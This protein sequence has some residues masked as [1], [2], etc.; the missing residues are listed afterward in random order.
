M[1][2]SHAVKRGTTKDIRDLKKIP[3]P[4]NP[5]LD[6]LYPRSAKSPERGHIQA[7]RAWAGIRGRRSTCLFPADHNFPT[8][9]QHMHVEG[10]RH[11]RDLLGLLIE[12]S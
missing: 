12:F 2:W 3:A 8:H 9:P 1:L 11:L 6:D 10:P 4:N 7:K 5:R